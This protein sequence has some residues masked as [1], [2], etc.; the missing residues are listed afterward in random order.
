ME[1]A[2]HL[3]KP[4]L[5]AAAMRA[6]DAFTI[7]ELGIPGFT[8]ME[9]A[10]REA[11]RMAAAWMQIPDS[12]AVPAHIV[13][14]TGKGNNGGDGL[15]LA[16]YMLQEGCRVTVLMTAGAVELT[17]DCAANL[18]VL[19]KMMHAGVASR[20][21]LQSAGTWTA[22]DLEGMQA[23]LL[24]DALLGT[25]LESGIRS[26]MDEIV[27]A[28]NENPAPVLALDLASGLSASSGQAFIPCV[29]AD[30][31]V[32]MGAV[33]AGHLLQDGPDRSGIVK[34]ADIG[35]PMAVLEREAGRPGSGFLSTDDWAV[36]QLRPRSRQDHK[37]S[38]GPTLVA[39]GS[40]DYPG[41][42]ALAA[43]AAARSG[44]GYV[45]VIGPDSIR[46][47]L[48]EMLDA[49]PVAAWPDGP[50][51][52]SSADILVEHLDARW[53]K[54]K[55]LLIG[56]GLGRDEEIRAWVWALLDRFDGPVVLDADALFAIKKYRER[57]A[58]SSRGR[59]ILTPH[60][61]ELARLDDGTG[62]DG[63]RISRVQRLA[64]AWNCVILAKGQPSITAAPDGRVIV[65]ATGHPAAATAGTGDVLAGI[66]V[67]LL[68]QGVH[69]FNAAAAGIHIGGTAASKFVER[70]AAQSLVASDIIDV[71]PD[72]LRHLT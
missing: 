41:A 3:L 19:E 58:A 17:P 25:G 46:S 26:P 32:T 70:G 21:T 63:S 18:Q 13:V 22:R 52:D 47:Q 66:T 30:V 9:T 24:V 16:R 51:R 55:A 40:A 44:S 33:K 27:R 23:D 61:G 60:E 62:E 42:P 72:V 64:T 15:V 2:N 31:T 10:G 34:V 50:F 71:L 8:L 28:I 59:W 65:N 38:T 5:D 53:S 57:V 35:I 37:Y 69:P 36:S 1:K 7:D 43:R 11:A 39:G 14:C 67:G 56:P 68:A 20:L 12:G 45:L 48:Q 54:A 6:A 29:Q 49:I 4:V